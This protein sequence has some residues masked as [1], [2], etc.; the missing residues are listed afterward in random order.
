LRSS[1]N[2]GRYSSSL[3]VGTTIEKIGTDVIIT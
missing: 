2:F 3:R 1:N